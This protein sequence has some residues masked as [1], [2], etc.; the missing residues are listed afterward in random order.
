MLD[1][2]TWVGQLDNKSIELLL[3]LLNILA[4]VIYW[5]CF[6]KT[7]LKNI[8]FSYFSVT[9]LLLHV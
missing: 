8:K 7:S 9:L 4:L 2:S 6:N 1:L 5:V 3:D